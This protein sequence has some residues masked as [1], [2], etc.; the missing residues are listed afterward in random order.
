MISLRVFCGS[1][2]I[3]METQGAVLRQ[4]M[5]HLKDID[6]LAFTVYTK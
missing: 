3:L 6:A 1:H 2:A 4:N 5:S